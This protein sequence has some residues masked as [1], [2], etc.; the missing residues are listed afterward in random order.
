MSITLYYSLCTER[1]G[2]IQ[3]PDGFIL[4][5]NLERLQSVIDN[6][7]KYSGDLSW[8]YS[9]IISFEPGNE[10]GL[11]FAAKLQQSIYFGENKELELL[12]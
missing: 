10:T 7:V 1:E 8:E 2:S 5:D 6:Q 12:L 3:R 9:A 11:Y 4:S